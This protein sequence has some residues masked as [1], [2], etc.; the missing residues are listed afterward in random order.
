[1]ADFAGGGAVTVFLEAIGRSSAS[2]AGNVLTQ[3]GTSAAATLMVTCYFSE[4]TTPIPLSAGAPL[5]VAG[6]GA[7]A[8]LR[9]M[10]RMRR[11]V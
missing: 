9:R 2:G 6:L 1:M 8:A 11:E 10:R 5:V 3:F 4:T 7:L